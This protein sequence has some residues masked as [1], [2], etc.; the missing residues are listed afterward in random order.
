MTSSVLHSHVN[1]D[2]VLHCAVPLGSTFANQDVVVTVNVAIES[3]VAQK[4]MRDFIEATA[5]KWQGEFELPR[6]GKPEE[7]EAF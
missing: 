5:G 7:R 3:T 4:S 2:G 1:D 6:G